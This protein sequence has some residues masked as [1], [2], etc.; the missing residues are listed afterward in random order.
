MRWNLSAFGLLL[1][2]YVGSKFVLEYSARHDRQRRPYSLFVSQHHCA[3]LFVRLLLWYRNGHDGS[4]SLPLTPHGET[5]TCGARKADRMLKQPDR[6]LGVILIGNNLVNFAATLATIIG[7]NLLNDTG[8]ARTLGINPNFLIFAE[9]APKTWQPSDQS[10]ALPA[11]Y[12]LEPLA[13]VLHPAVLLINS[14]SNALVKPFLPERSDGNDQLTKD[15][16]I[17]VVNRVPTPLANASS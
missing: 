13:K 4:E 6:L 16:L 8:V 9:V 17:T 12:A 14:F 15:E 1:L 7:Y 3:D 10:L 2:G 5:Q 11:V